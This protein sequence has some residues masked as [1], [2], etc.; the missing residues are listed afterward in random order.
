MTTTHEPRTAQDG[1]AP[2]MVGDLDDP[3]VR[4]II[5]YQAA[6]ARGDL[7]A[8]R[9]VFWPDVVYVV[10]G[11]SSLA[12]TYHGPDEVIGYLARLVQLTDGTYGIS[13]MSWTTGGDSVALATVNSA[14]RGG[15]SL[16]WTEVI[17]FTF[18]EGRKKRIEL[19]SGDQ[20]GFDALFS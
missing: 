18:V 20:Y 14:T 10:P 7:D 8:A 12:G 2:E 9:T 17:V 6:V 3:R 15:R 4:A 19:T 5:N 1:G 11:R 16:T 13:R